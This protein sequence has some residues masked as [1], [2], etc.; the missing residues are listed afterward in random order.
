MF[1]IKQFTGIEAGYRFDNSNSAI[2]PTKGSHF[3]LGGGYVQNIKDKD[4]AF[5][6]ASSSF[7]LYLPLGNAF[8][9]AFRAGGGILNGDA[10]YYHF[11]T[12]G[13]NENL[14]GYPR[15][16]FFGKNT[17]YN[18]NEFR[19]VVPTSNYFFAG[20][21]GLL[22]FFDNGRV[23]QPGENSTLWH[24][25]YGGGLVIIPF[26]KAGLNR[27][28]GISKQRTHVLLRKLEFF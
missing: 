1:N 13:G 22:A 3:V 11:N 26:N 2:Y 16:R 9:L 18:N 21:I 7:A 27:T 23:W 20:K 15:E 4:R 19:W 10:D 14:R 6:K 24:R 17:F 25:G 8:S 28:Y 12:L 5:F